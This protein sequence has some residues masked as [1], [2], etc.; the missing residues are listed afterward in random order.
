DHR[1]TKA[2]DRR[3]ARGSS[4]RR[5][6]LKFVP[7]RPSP[8]GRTIVSSLKGIRYGR[9]VP[10]NRDCREGCPAG[11]TIRQQQSRERPMR[12]ILLLAAASLALST[13]AYAQTVK[14]SVTAIVEHPALDAVRDGV[15]DGLGEAGY[16]EGENLEF[17]YESA[18]GNTATAAQIAREF[19]GNNPNVIV[20][21]STPS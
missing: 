19:V 16:K 7:M 11:T 13:A 17:T 10:G 21:I 2:P 9:G 12:K 4:I 20:P 1:R 3:Q 18:Q 6:S 15:R 8:S 14:V 5:Y